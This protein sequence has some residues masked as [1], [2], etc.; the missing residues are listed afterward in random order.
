M[1]PIITLIICTTRE[2]DRCYRREWP[3]AEPGARTRNRY[4]AKQISLA[5]LVAS[6]NLVALRQGNF[7]PRGYRARFFRC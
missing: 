2:N 1:N 5:S 4:N 3:H 6:F 7:R